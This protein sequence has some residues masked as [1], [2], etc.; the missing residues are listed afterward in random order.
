MFKFLNFI[1]ES[2]NTKS[3]KWIK[4]DFNFRKEAIFKTKN[5]KEYHICFDEISNDV[6]NIHFYLLENGVEI[7][8]LTN[9]GEEFQILGNLKNCIKDF[10]QNNRQ[11]IEFIGYS[12]FEAE[13]E[14]LY[15][16]LQKE[17]IKFDFNVYRKRKNK[18]T[19]YFCNNKDISNMII[20]KYEKLFISYDRKNKKY[21]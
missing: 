15:I 8:K 4:S 12:S 1:S 11:N 17:L 7:I 14:D 19:Y 21:E 13:R 20:D 9:N 18:I 5:K 16:M 2:L 10:I 6:Y 3:Y